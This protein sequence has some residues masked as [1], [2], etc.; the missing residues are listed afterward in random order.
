M[1]NA[2]PATGLPFPLDLVDA[3]I[4]VDRKVAREFADEIEA[5]LLLD[6][7]LNAEEVH[8][9]FISINPQKEE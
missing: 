3:N 4:S 7:E 2:N 5:R 9:E 8:G 1:E 6:H